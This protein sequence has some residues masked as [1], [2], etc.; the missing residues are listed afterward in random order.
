MCFLPKQDLFV[1]YNF[2]ALLMQAQ[3]VYRTK[4]SIADNHSTGKCNY[5]PLGR[6]ASEDFGEA[7]GL[8]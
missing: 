7:A 1:V 6:G 8:G 4:Y 2:T 3:G 5:S